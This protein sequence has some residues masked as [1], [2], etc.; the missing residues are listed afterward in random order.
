[1]I[2]TKVR[3]DVSFTIQVRSQQEINARRGVIMVV[4]GTVIWSSAG[5]IMDRLIHGYRMTPVELSL[6][7]LLVAVPTLALFIAIYKPDALRLSVRELPYYAAY[8]IVGI[9]ISH[10]AW[11]AS[12]QVNRAAV[13]TAL[14]FSAPVFVAV[15]GRLLFGE[16]LDYLRTGAIVVNVL[17]CFLVSG[18]YH[19]GILM[20]N[21]RG[22]E[23]GLATGLA[24]AAYTLMGKHAAAAGRRDF[25]TILLY[26]LSFGLVGVLIWGLASEGPR[27]VVT[28]LDTFGWLLLVGVGLGP[29]LIGYGCYNAALKYLPATVAAL[30]TTL[31]P[32][33]TGILAFLFLGR[34][35]DGIQWFGIVLIVVGVLVMQAG[36]V[37][38]LWNRSMGVLFDEGLLGDGESQ[39]KDG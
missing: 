3:P 12:I 34:L 27:V 7:R 30:I 26:V 36:T 39:A 38:V 10:I 32:F 37:H 28:H 20:Q 8:G 16:R 13:A 9:A 23:L 21:P 31:E 19:L 33:M 5:V 2:P 17:G 25:L 18:A 11:A 14:V 29:T 15:A 35:M 6:W 4:L 1:M 22:A 24:F